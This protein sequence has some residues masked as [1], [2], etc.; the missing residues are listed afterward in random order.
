VIRLLLLL[1]AALSADVAVAV[2]AD[3]QVIATMDEL[4]F[5]APKEKGKAELVDE[6]IGKGRSVPVRQGALPATSSSN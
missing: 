1:L 2:V 4:V 6:K 3:G 5:T